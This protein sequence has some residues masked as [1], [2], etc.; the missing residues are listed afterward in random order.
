MNNVIFVCIYSTRINITRH[1]RSVDKHYSNVGNMVKVICSNAVGSFWSI[2][3]FLVIF[4]VW[5]FHETLAHTCRHSTLIN[6]NEEWNWFGIIN[7][8]FSIYKQVQLTFLTQQYMKVSISQ[9][10]AAYSFYGI[11]SNIT[12]CI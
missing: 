5:I 8:W 12:F 4:D 3:F 2:I 1:S 7:K 9:K 6:I 11:I 10:V